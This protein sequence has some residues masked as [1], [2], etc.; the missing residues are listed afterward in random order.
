MCAGT[1]SRW[2]GTYAYACTML[3]MLHLNS[4]SMYARRTDAMH[5]LDRPQFRQLC[6]AYLHAS[7]MACPAGPGG[8][9]RVNGHSHDVETRTHAHS[10]EARATSHPV[11]PT[12][13]RAAAAALA[14]LP[15]NSTLQATYRRQRR[16]FN[17]SI[18]TTTTSYQLLLPL[19]SSRSNACPS[20]VR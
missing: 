20:H 13:T 10:Q 17:I 5:R 6:N 4:C 11:P 8:Y 2:K 18:V 3:T 15:S 16:R 9:K 14:Q 19:R 1:R 7:T 12:L